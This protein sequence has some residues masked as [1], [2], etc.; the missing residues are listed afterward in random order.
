MHHPVVLTAVEQHVPRLEVAAAEEQHVLHQHVLEG[1]QAVVQAAWLR[2]DAFEILQM[3][4]I[5]IQHEI[6]KMVLQVGL[7]QAFEYAFV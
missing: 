1:E 3:Q 4:T 5:Y 7:A 2:H 6:Q